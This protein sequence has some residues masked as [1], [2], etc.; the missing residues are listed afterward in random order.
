MHTMILMISIYV[1]DGVTCFITIPQ[2]VIAVA[3]A[4]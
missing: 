3:A 4:V 1:A 2:S